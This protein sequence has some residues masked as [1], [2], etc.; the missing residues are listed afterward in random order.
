MPF[1]LTNTPATFQEMMNDKLKSIVKFVVFFFND[2]L[3]Y[4]STEDD[5]LLHLGKL[6]ETLATNHLYVKKSKCSFRQPQIEYLGRDFCC[7]CDH[8]SKEDRSSPELAHP[9]I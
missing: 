5:H 4:N 8:E 7:R 1:G 3:V 2:I 6:V 9:K